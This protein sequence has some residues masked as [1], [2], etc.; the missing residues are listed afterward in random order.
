MMDETH[1]D[2]DSQEARAST[3]LFSRRRFIAATGL[4]ATGAIAGCQ[5]SGDGEGGT[6]SDGGSDGGD[7]GDASDPTALANFRGSGPLVEARGPPGGT[8]IT[9][10]PDLSGELTLYLGGGEGGL[11]LDLIDRFQQVYPDLVVDPR[12]GASSSLANTIIE[13]SQ[14]GTSPADL[15]LAVDAGSLGS[16][17]NQDATMSLPSEVTEMVPADVRTDQWVGFAGRARAVPYNTN[18]FSDSDLPDTVQEFPNSSALSGSLGWAPTYSAFQSFVTAM[19]LIRGEEETRQ[20]LLD[21]QDSGVTEF[22]NE[23]FVSNSVADGT[24]S[25]GLANHYYALR[26]QNSRSNA[27]IDLHFTSGDAGALINVSGAQIISGTEKQDLAVNFIRHLLSS[28][29]QEFF[30]TQTFAYPTVPDVAPAGGLPS[31]DELNPPDVDLAQLSD[32]N[33]TLEL[34]RDTNVL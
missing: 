16:V 26:V 28:E 3:G 10:M 29:A 12:R 13:E 33:P 34:L 32:V 20:W 7:G 24:I 15:F 1:A 4:V 23:F 19:R 5:D 18:E 21:M 11:Y 9:E 22:D 6:P 30:A 27:P 8:S 14:A 2:G 31:I 25:A 17:A